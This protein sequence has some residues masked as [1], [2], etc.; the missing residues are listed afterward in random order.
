M[1][2]ASSKT[3]PKEIEDPSSSRSSLSSTSSTSIPNLN[4]ISSGSTKSVAK[5]ENEEKTKTEPSEKLSKL[6]VSTGIKKPEIKV[7]VK[8]EN[9]PD[10]MKEV[11]LE[12]KSDCTNEEL[13]NLKKEIKDLNEKLE[14]LKIKRSEDRERIRESD[15][16]KIQYQ[17]LQ[18]YK[19]QAQ[20]MISQLNKDIQQIRQENKSIKEEYA[21]YRDEMSSFESR[22]EE[23]TVD[24]EL[25]EEKA[26]E[27]EEQFNQIKEKLEETK[28]ELD[29]LKGEIETNGPE[30][31]NNMYQN[32]QLEN[33]KMALYKLS[34][35]HKQEKNNSNEL[36]KKNEELNQK[37]S[38]ISK[39]L[40][41]Y[42][43][44]RETLMAQINELNEQVTAS[45]GSEKIIETLSERN[46]DLES[47]VA[48]YEEEIADLEAINEVND[49]LQENAK[50]EE[51]EL[52]QNLDLAESRIRDSEKK[53]EQLKYNIA[54]HEKTIVKFR[55]LVKQLQGEND[56]ISR[57]L[58]SKLEQE[59][60]TLNNAVN[61]SGNS[62]SFDFKQKYFENQIQSKTIENEVNL[63]EL[64][65]AKNHLSYLL[66][67][68][69]D[70]FI[71]QSGISIFY[72]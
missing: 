55:E 6:A 9:K 18:E 52:R 70:S 24:K 8:T 36:S 47:K 72:F 1:T 67:F 65:S 50:E 49:Q 22:I 41:S 17:Q 64:Q 34:D 19:V 59:Q 61:S 23:L 15:K 60:E 35:L 20:E 71:K 68:M 33:Y 11:V 38:K 27:L 25:A 46:L 13:I 4:R 10:L 54:D 45:L 28:L 57:Q 48:K 39:E 31:V 58:K 40:D 16:L 62:Q 42:K 5:S 26:E 66:S 69:S 43:D 56:S 51:R 32:E 21:A 14:T 44:E 63:V 30:G 37:L 29:V 7:E 53:I 2:K 3:E 12:E